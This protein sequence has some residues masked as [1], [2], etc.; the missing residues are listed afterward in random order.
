MIKSTPQQLGLVV[1]G[2]PLTAMLISHGK[3]TAE[4][5]FFNPGLE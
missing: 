2:T 5:S 3:Q 4:T 1:T